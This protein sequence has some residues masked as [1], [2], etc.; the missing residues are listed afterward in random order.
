MG[1]CSTSPRARRAHTER[2]DVLVWRRVGTPP[3]DGLVETTLGAANDRHRPSTAGDLDFLP[4]LTA[5]RRE[6]SCER[7]SAT[8]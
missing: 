7:A 5:S 8:L 3:G 2:K 6:V 1:V 4:A